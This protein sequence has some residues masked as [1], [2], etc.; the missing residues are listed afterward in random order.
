MERVRS[1]PAVREVEATGMGNEMV[2][3]FALKVAKSV[4]RR[5][6]LTLAVAVAIARLFVVRTMGVVAVREVEAT[7]MGKVMGN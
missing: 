6:P 5:N 1:R 2:G 3:C 7:G 4:E